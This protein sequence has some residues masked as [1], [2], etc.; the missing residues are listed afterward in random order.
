VPVI[1]MVNALRT[2]ATD[3]PDAPALTVADET[4]TYAELDERTDQ[5]ARALAEFDITEGD[6]V[7][8]AL[9]NSVEFVVA[10]IAILKL[11]A[12]VQPVSS[13]LPER[14]RTAIVELAKSKLVIGA[15]RESSPLHVPDISALRPRQAN[16]PLPAEPVSQ[17]WRATT[18]GGSSGRP[19]LITTAA[20][21]VW[22]PPWL[23]AVGAMIESLSRPRGHSVLF[24]RQVV[25]PAAFGV[26]PLARKRQGR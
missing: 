17:P 7:T 11:G 6:Y 16:R 4:L 21:R 18:S 10:T 19:K 12:V 22:T 25:L 8:V 2:W 14:E 26:L 15:S 5:V 3:H 1:P 9:P 23:L 24:S 13:R 20:P